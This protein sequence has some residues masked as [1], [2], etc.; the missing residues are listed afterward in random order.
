MNIGRGSPNNLETL[1]VSL[2]QSEVYLPGSSLYGAWSRE[3]LID[4]RKL[5]YSLGC[6][7]ICDG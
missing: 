1:V 7:T 4:F 5:K 2:E 3:M 6:T